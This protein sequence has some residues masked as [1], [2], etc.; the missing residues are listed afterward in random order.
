MAE[1]TGFPQSKSELFRNG[2]TY[3]E[4]VD[5]MCCL[6]NTDAVY[7]MVLDSTSYGGTPGEKDAWS[8]FQQKEK[9]WQ[10]EQRKGKDSRIASVVEM[11]KRYESHSMFDEC[12]HLKS[13]PKKFYLPPQI[14]ADYAEKKR[15]EMGLSKREFNKKVKNGEIVV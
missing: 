5:L 13:L 12:A 8:K 7:E 14:E 3:D 15:K 4:L 1:G 9:E 2:F 6:S 11:C 10:E